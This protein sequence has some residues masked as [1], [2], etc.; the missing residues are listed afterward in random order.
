M[1]L[2]GPEPGLGELRPLAVPLTEA[3]KF[4]YA[5]FSSASACWSTIE[6]TSFSHARSGVFLIAV[7]QAD[8][9]LSVM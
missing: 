2:A 4:R 5:M 8:R 3:K 9:S 6:E 1:I 7:S